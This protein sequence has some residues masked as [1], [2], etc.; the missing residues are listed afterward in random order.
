MTFL[1]LIACG[2]IAVFCVAAVWSHKFTDTLAQ[3]IALSCGGLG[4]M[5]TGWYANQNPLPGPVELLIWATALFCAATGHKLS[6]ERK[7]APEEVQQQA[8]Q[9]EAE[10]P[11]QLRVK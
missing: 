5:G 1:T 8:P 11:M 9:E 3:R 4:A 2:L 7:K 6:Q 10:R